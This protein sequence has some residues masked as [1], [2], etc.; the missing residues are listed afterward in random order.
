MGWLALTL[1]MI[2]GS[3]DLVNRASQGKSRGPR[4]LHANGKAVVS[5]P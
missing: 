4:Q 5:F 3:R 1:L 2:P